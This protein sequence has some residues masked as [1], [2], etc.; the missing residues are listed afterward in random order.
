MKMQVDIHSPL[1]RFFKVYKLVSLFLGQTPFFCWSHPEQCQG[2]PILDVTVLSPLEHVPGP[3]I[4]TKRT[5]RKQPTVFSQSQ[6]AVVLDKD[7]R[8]NPVVWIGASMDVSGKKFKFKI[9][10]CFLSPNF[11]GLSW[12]FLGSRKTKIGVNA[13]FNHIFLEKEG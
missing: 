9:S 13:I 11:L 8:G 5:A 10:T 2:N 4:E 3:G 12:V 1:E 7:K 6:A